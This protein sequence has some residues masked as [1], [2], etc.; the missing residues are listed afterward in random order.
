MTHKYCYHPYRWRRRPARVVYIGD[1][2]IGGKHPLAIQ[3][4]TTTDTLNTQ[5]TIKQTLRMVEAGCEI[6]RIT[7]P[8]NKHAQ[9]LEQIKN[10]LIKRGC[11]VPLVADIHFTP[12]AALIAADYVEKVRI[13]PGNYADRKRFTVQE[14]TDAEYKAEL[15][16]LEEKF[17]PLVEKCKRLGRSMR[18]GT[19]HGSLSDRIMNRYGDTPS[20]MVESALEFVRICEKY[21]YHDLVLSMKAS[22]TQVMIQAYRLLAAC[23]TEENMTY[24]F[25]LGVTEAGDGL[26]GRI[27]SA[28]GIGALLEDGIGDTLR[29]SLTEA[30][31]FEIEPARQIR[32]KYNQLIQ[33]EEKLRV[34]MPSRVFSKEESKSPYEYRRRDS[35]E[36]KVG[37]YL[38]GGNHPVRVYSPLLELTS[39]TDTQN[40]VR[41]M[42]IG[43]HSC[44]ILRL[45]IFSENLDL[46][47]QLVTWLKEE[48]IDLPISAK[49]DQ[50]D[51]LDILTKWA[52]EIYHIVYDLES[53]Q[54]MLLATEADFHQHQAVL[55]LA[56]PHQEGSD[57][58]ATI[59]QMQMMAEFCHEYDLPVIFSI[60]PQESNFPFDF[61]VGN[62]RAAADLDAPLALCFRR[63]N[64]ELEPVVTCATEFGAL[65]CDGIG[66]AIMMEC[67]SWNINTYTQIAYTIL[68]ATRVRISKTEF[69]S[70]PSC[71]R[72]LFDL[73]E[74]TARI[75]TRTGHLKGVKIAIMGCIVNGP[76][77]MADADFGY[78]GSG[79][80]KIDLYVGQERVKRNLSIEEADQALIDLIKKHGKWQEPS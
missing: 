11:H 36:V 77:E 14:Y 66:D 62:Y 25:H 23:M 61:Q 63:R 13:N 45:Q 54:G 3:S 38:I 59:Q 76:G 10:G 64:P 2:P 42:I 19:N 33:N 48:G 24:P 68:Q 60:Y 67:D 51:D 15:E 6:V 1:V 28:V 4:M 37:S 46:L 22:N 18:I 50:F 65:L 80:G 56:F 43:D 72:T 47:D 8:S 5:E 40:Q 7:A 78:V 69:I 35:T 29:V 39:L 57:L 53:I 41:E 32:Y 27:K 75:K 44:E 9:N 30:P 55:H 12:N 52:A 73:M 17:V 31:E 74:T 20:G 26:D 49:I 34:Y 16:Q 71:G 58:A 21:D 79:I 70:C